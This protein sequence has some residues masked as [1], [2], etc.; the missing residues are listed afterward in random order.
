MHS[1][2]YPKYPVLFLAM[3]DL[4]DRGPDQ[5]FSLSFLDLHAHL[6]EAYDLRYSK[7]GLLHAIYH[8]ENSGSLTLDECPTLYRKNG[9]LPDQIVFS[10]IEE[11]LN[12]LTR[13]YNQIESI[14]DKKGVH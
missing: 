11:G 1:L 2:S 8:L 9:F 7:D 14:L 10:S 3:L 12:R 4:A 6:V 13:L 5:K